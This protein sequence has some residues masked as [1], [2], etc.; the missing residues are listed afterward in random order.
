[1]RKYR[2]L[3][4]KHKG[5]S[6]FYPQ[7]KGVNMIEIG[8]GEVS[9]YQYFWKEVDYKG[10]QMIKILKFNSIDGA[11]SHIEESI[12]INAVKKEEIP[13]EIIIHEYPV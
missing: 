5:V 13:S 4:E 11:K 1:M 2:I 6:R 12:E 10:V 3:E 9:G 8:K 7:Y